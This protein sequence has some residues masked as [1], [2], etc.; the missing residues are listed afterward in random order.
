MCLAWSTHR[1]G[2]TRIGTS[3]YNSTVLS[4]W[5]ELCWQNRALHRTS[6]AMCLSVRDLEFSHP[7]PMQV[8]SMTQMWPKCVVELSWAL[9]VFSSGIA[10]W[11]SKCW[12]L[13]LSWWKCGWNLKLCCRC[14]V[15]FVTLSKL[16]SICPTALFVKQRQWHFQ[17]QYEE[18]VK[19]SILE[20]I[21]SSEQSVPDPLLQR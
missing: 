6:A 2:F 8:V 1:D 15:A 20:T 4:V 13:W 12:S 10:C 18:I 3:V 7:C 9:V 17:I 16:V 19:I 5:A 11:V 21:K 14:L